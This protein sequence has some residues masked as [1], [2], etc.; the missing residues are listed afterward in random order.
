MPGRQFTWAS[1]ADV[2]TYEKLGRVLVSTD[3][4]LKFPLASV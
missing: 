3:W 4:E 2:P 1:Y